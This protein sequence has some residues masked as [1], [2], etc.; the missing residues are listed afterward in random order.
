MDWIE[1]GPWLRREPET[2]AE[3][4]TGDR[5]QEPEARRR[6]GLWAQWPG[7]RGAESQ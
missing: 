6:I 2:Q 5:R 4:D 7:G 3:G 1:R